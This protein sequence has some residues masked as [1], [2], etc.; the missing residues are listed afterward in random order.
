MREAL[1]D[2]DSDLPAYQLAPLREAWL[3]QSATP[4]FAAF[5]MS[6]FSALAGVLACVGIY[7][8]LAFAVGQRSREIA[9]RRAIGASGARVARGVVHDALRLAMIGLLVGAAAAAGGAR[10]LEGFLFGVETTDPLTFGLVA[11]AMVAVALMAALVPA[12]R[13]LSRDPAE[14][15]HAD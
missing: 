14:A 3:T 7:G 6:L 5:L 12:M 1:S 4:R 11:A 13:V 2:L 8:V 9:V 15:L 10:V